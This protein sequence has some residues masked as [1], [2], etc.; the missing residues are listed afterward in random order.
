LR[1][2]SAHGFVAHGLSGQLRDDGGASQA[3][4]QPVYVPE[5][6]ARLHLNAWIAPDVERWIASDSW[7]RLA[8]RVVDGVFRGRTK[9][10]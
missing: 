4:K 5:H 1:T 6:L 8:G 3:A 7:E 2:V 9:A 10:G